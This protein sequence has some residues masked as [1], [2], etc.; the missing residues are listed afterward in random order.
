MNPVY[1][2]PIGII[3]FIAGTRV[4][5]FAMYERSA[6]ESAGVLFS[7]V[8]VPLILAGVAC[9]GGAFCLTWH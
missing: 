1:F 4:L 8:G 9:V 7:F 6:S 3:A 2:I 5:R